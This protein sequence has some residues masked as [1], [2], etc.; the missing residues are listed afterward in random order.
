MKYK[1]V[2]FSNT[3]PSE[4]ITEVL[5]E[6]ASARA[7]NIEIVRLNLAHTE[8]SIKKNFSAVTKTLKNMKSLGRIQFYATKDSFRESNTEAIFLI[9][10]YPEI[11]DNITLATE[12]TTYFFVKL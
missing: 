9:N 1:V 4:L 12:N 11:F 6:L 10:K 7:D 5:F 3:N 2:D 8:E